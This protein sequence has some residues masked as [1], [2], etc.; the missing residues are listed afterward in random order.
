MAFPEKSIVIVGGGIVGLCLGVAALA[1][2][3]STTLI[4]RDEVRAT[5]SGVAAGMIAP[6]LEA[7]GDPEPVL[8]FQRLKAAQNAWLGT[9]DLWPEPVQQALAEGMSTPT[10]YSWSSG[11]NPAG[12]NEVVRPVIEAMGARFVQ[13]DDDALRIEGLDSEGESAIRVDDDWLVETTRILDALESGFTMRGG[14]IVRGEAVSV[15]ANAVVLGDGRELH[16]DRVVVASGY[17]SRAFAATIPSLG[18]LTPIKGH[19]LDLPSQGAP[20]VTRTATGYLA[21]YGASA[22]FGASME[23]GREDLDVDPA[24]VADLKARATQLFREIATGDAVPRTGIR[25]STPDGWPLIGL[26]SASGVWLAVG[27]RRNGYVFAPFAADIILDGIEGRA[28]P[29]AE[30]YDPQR[31]SKP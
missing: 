20:G 19:L 12:S 4:A 5:A 26:D 7:I 21:D 15:T 25:A 1:R 28:R 24:M 9:F 16:G 31:F 18:V 13:L 30:A 6:V 23:H 10:L 8:A 29:D 17:G 3:Y 11:F 27:M 14:L 22:K 2:G